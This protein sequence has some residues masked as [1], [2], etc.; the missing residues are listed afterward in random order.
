MKQPSIMTQ[1]IGPLVAAALLSVQVQAKSDEIYRSRAADGSIIFSDQPIP[2]A[3]SIEIRPTQTVPAFKDTPSDT[4]P[5]KKT[6]ESSQAGVY[7]QL[8]IASPINDETLRENAGTVTVTYI[9]NPPLKDKKW[10]TTCASGSMARPSRRPPVTLGVTVNNVDRGDHE[11]VG[12]IL[13]DEGVVLIQ[14]DKTVF[15]LRRFSKLFKEND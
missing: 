15:H 10:Y 4:A 6:G 12:E 13:S 5:T 7:Q 11:L 14:S 2:G 9:S 8:M 1:L 3:E